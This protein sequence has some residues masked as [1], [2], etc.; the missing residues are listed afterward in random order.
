MTRLA[1]AWYNIIDDDGQLRCIIK[2]P[3]NGDE[4]RRADE[5][6]EAKDRVAPD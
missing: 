3:I 4:N 2:H 1:V 5:G 6:L